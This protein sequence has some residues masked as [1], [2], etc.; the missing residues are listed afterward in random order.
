MM[1]DAFI[2]LLALAS[3][4][5]DMPSSLQARDE[6]MLAG[7]KRQAPRG[8]ATV[9]LDQPLSTPAH[10]A[11]GFIY[12]IPDNGVCHDYR[13]QLGPD[14]R[15]CQGRQGEPKGH[16]SSVPWSGDPVTTCGRLKSPS[17]LIRCCL[18]RRYRRLSNNVACPF[19]RR[20][21]GAASVCLLVFQSRAE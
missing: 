12:G 19:Y 10:L 3:S 4:G 1:R 9:S 2:P 7:V 15:R 14:P 13:R 20:Y 16:T 6:S 21:L 11:S 5:L 8:T 18:P 17:R